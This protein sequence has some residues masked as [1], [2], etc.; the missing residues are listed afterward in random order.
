MMRSLVFGSTFVAFFAFEQMSQHGITG[1]LSGDP[2]AG[3]FWRIVADM[4]IVSAVELRDPVPLFV[5]VV[6]DDGL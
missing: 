5:S 4:L 3:Y 2:F 6:A 1:L